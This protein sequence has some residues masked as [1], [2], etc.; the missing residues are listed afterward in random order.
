MFALAKPLD[1][2]S[3]CW[4]ACRRDG[5]DSGYYSVL[6]K[7]CSCVRLEDFADLIKPVEVVP[8]PPAYIPP[9][10]WR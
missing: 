8:L 4:A 2:D 6:A 3:V 5:Y 10:E 1:R 9:P 7:K